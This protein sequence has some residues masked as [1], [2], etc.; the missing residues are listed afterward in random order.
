MDL[1]EKT[2]FFKFKI[3]EKCSYDRIFF[4]I[5]VRTYGVSKNADLFADSKFVE[6]GSKS[7]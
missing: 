3:C 6:M 4:L 2:P 5:K 1:K 7:P